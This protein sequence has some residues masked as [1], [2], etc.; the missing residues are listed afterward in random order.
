MALLDGVKKALKMCGQAFTMT[1]HDRLETMEQRQA[2]TDN[3]MLRASIRLAEQVRRSGTYEVIPVSGSESFHPAAAL[4]RHLYSVFPSHRAHVTGS[5][6]SWCREL[7][8][9]GYTI[10]GAGTGDSPVS[11]LRIGGT[12]DPA[13]I[14]PRN[15]RPAVVIVDLETAAEARVNEMRALDY[16]WYIV[17]EHPKACEA[18][19][20]YANYPVVLP[21]W[22]GETIFFRDHATF[23]HALRWCEAVLRQVYFGPAAESD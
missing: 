6:A 13:N 3:V 15:A 8:R 14:D 2:E 21:E 7:A 9:A 12:F 22:R 10:E 11:I 20:F 17:L 18:G 5:D 4:A 16:A 1:V 23:L 19:R